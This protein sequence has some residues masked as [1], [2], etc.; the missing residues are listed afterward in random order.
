MISGECGEGFELC[1]GDVRA[2]VER[3]VGFRGK[4][5]GLSW[6]GFRENILSAP[7]RSL[8]ATRTYLGVSGF[9]RS[10]FRAEGFGL[11][12]GRFRAFWG[13]FRAFVLR[14]A[15]VRGEGLGPLRGGK[16]GAQRLLLGSSRLLS[17]GCEAVAPWTWVA[18]RP[19]K[20]SLG[21]YSICTVSGSF[22]RQGNI[23]NESVQET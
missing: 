12:W 10:G 3:V 16:L 15:G 8:S 2:S 1:W 22:R 5:F 11:S 9:R 4:G 6:G 21:K 14:V 23:R 19:G 20:G 18:R 17:R 7:F 13:G